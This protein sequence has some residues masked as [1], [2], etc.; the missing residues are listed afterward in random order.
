MQVAVV[1]GGMVGLAFALAIKNGCPGTDIRVLEA[2][3]PKTGAPPP[4]DSRATAL[5]LASR[6]LLDQWGIW[7]QVAP[8]AADIL[9]IHVSS[10]GRFG[11]ALMEAVDVGESAP[12]IVAIDRRPAFNQQRAEDAS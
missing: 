11:S 12:S 4:L 8:S 7:Q 1:G 6:S 9:A 2:R 10:K 3:T 5:N